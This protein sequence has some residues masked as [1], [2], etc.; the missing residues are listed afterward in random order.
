MKLTKLLL[1]ITTFKHS[2]HASTLASLL[3]VADASAKSLSPWKT[4]LNILSSRTMMLGATPHFDL[5]YHSQSV[6]A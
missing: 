6:F 3:V 2:G 5:Q 4:H 1:T